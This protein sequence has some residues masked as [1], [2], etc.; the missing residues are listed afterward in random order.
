MSTIVAGERTAAERL[1]QAR[2]SPENARIWALEAA[3]VDEPADSSGPLA[4]ALTEFEAE[5]M[6]QQPD[7]VVL[8]DDSDAALA[9]ALVATK[10][11]IQVTAADGAR[12]PSS[13]NGR[14]IA[15]LAGA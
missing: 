9:A 11:L 3:P 6:S 13:V 2:E 8:A 14:L 4:R 7:L 5:A 10:L 15:Q 1:A 12:V